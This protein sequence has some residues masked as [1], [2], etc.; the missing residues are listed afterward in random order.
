MSASTVATEKFLKLA[1]EVTWGLVANFDTSEM[2]AWYSTK[3]SVSITRTVG[4]TWPRTKPPNRPTEKTALDRLIPFQ[5]IGASCDSR[6]SSNSSPLAVSR[7]GAL[8]TDTRHATAC[9]IL[10]HRRER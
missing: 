10:C 5:I 4:G 8:V 3:F 7:T 2:S 9:A 1:E 6:P